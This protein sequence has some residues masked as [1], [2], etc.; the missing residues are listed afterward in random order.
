MARRHR[1]PSPAAVGHC[2]HHRP[3]RVQLI[4][5]FNTGASLCGFSTTRNRCPSGAG[6]YAEPDARE[7]RSN[8]ARKRGWGTTGRMPAH[9]APAR[10]SASRDLTVSPVPC[11]PVSI[12]R[13]RLPMVRRAIDYSAWGT[14][15]RRLSLVALPSRGSDPAPIWRNLSLRRFG[16]RIPRRST[17][18]GLAPTTCVRSRSTESAVT[19][20]VARPSEGLSVGVGNNDLFTTA[21]V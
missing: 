8:D 19:G 9:P 16:Q 10:P 15:S 6:E 5:T 3:P 7:W 2:Q 11:R 20:N 1:V 17:V 18:K 12:A 13:P 4:T 14:S 21:S